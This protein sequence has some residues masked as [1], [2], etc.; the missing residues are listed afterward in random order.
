MVPA[1]V[2]A[3]FVDLWICSSLDGGELVISGCC[4][5]FSV[6][7]TIRGVEMVG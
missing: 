1:P 3:C 4:R 5:P 7:V 6:N 2:G